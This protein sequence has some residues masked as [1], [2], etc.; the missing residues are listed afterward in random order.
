MS[1]AGQEYNGQVSNEGEGGRGGLTGGGATQV[2]YNDSAD[3][4]SANLRF[5]LLQQTNTG[6][7]VVYNDTRGLNDITPS[8]SGRSLI[9]K[10]SQI[11]DLID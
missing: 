5:G 9:I 2:Q 11:F 10:F 1:P 8:G 6:L 4:W 7:F 3:L